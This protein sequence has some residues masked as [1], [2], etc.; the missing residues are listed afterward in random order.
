MLSVEDFEQALFLSEHS[1]A[2]S[3]S[4]SQDGEDGRRRRDCRTSVLFSREFVG[5]IDDPELLDSSR[6]SEVVLLSCSLRTSLDA[7]PASA[8]DCCVSPAES[9]FSLDNLA[10]K[11]SSENALVPL[12]DDFSL[13]RV[14]Y[15]GHAHPD[16]ECCCRLLWPSRTFYLY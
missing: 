15:V 2:P 8:R 1:F 16:D 4:M 11:R 5:G 10:R 7:C 14:S 12:I 3:S 9:G 6:G 13:S